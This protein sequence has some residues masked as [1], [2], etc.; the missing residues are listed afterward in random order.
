MQKSYYL[1]PISRELYLKISI[2]KSMMYC[3][4]VWGLYHQ[5]WAM[6]REQEEHIFPF[7]LNPTQAKKYAEKHWPQYEPRK[8][9]SKDFKD[10]LL[11]TLN[12]LK[13]KPALCH[14]SSLTFKLNTQLMRL[15]F[16]QDSQHLAYA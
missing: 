10:S 12:R 6:M 4:M 2:L 8:I 11:P 14:H 15:F 5:G 7:W 13:V 9:S 16:F 1:A 3:G